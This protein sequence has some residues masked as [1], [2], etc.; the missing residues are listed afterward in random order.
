MAMETQHP[1]DISSIPMPLE[2]DTASSGVTLSGYQ[3]FQRSEPIQIQVE[4]QSSAPVMSTTYPESAYQWL[5]GVLDGLIDFG[6]RHGHYGVIELTED[7]YQWLDD[8]LEELIYSV[9][10]NQSHPLS[11]LMKFIIRIIA[12]YED[13]YVPKLTERFP[14]LAEEAP[15]ETSNKSKQPA[16]NIP[17]KSDS[18]LA[19][20]AFFSIG[21]LLSHGNRTEKAISAYDTAIVLKPDFWEAFY[22]LGIVRNSF[23]QYKEAIAYFNKVTKLNSDFPKT[24]YSRGIAH[25]KLIQYKEAMVDFDKAI[26]L[27]PNFANAYYNRG[28]MKSESGNYEGAI[29][30]FNRG[31]KSDPD[32]VKLHFNRGTAKANLKQYESAIADFDKVIELEPNIADAY[33][34][35]ACAKD[36]LNQHEAAIADF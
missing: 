6:Q 20:H 30:D 8:V 11:P 18:E 2:L 34:N 21:F 12:N 23:S 26:E 3:L 22:N 36:F 28:T 14:E 15:I 4:I 16:S 19:A 17:K 10:E 9:G 27:D 24:Y 29:A 33:Y 7:E 32:S 35:R 1:F 31:I 5:V 13:A 25:F